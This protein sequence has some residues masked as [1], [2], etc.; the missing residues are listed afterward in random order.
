MVAEKLLPVADISLSGWNRLRKNSDSSDDLKGCG[1]HRLR[2]NSD[3]SHA[4][5][6]CGTAS[7]RTPSRHCSNSEFF[8]SLVLP[9]I[10]PK[11]LRRCWPVAHFQNDS[12][13]RG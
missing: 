3:S 10:I 6:G 2:K 4:L 9:P 12:N 7:S 8:P 1:F 11:P 5:K 13:F